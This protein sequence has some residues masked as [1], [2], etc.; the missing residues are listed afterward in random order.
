ML[1]NALVSSFAMAEEELA[2][3]ASGLGADTLKTLAEVSQVADEIDLDT[4]KV[5]ASVLG[6]LAASP[7]IIAIPVL[8]GLAVASIVGFGIIKYSEGN[9][10]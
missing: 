4:S 10:D 2:T 3:A 8:A 6:K 7:A 1:P 9:N 5:V